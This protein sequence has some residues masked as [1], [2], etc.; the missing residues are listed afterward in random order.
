MWQ[1]PM[2]VHHADCYIA[3][4]YN[5]LGIFFFIFVNWIYVYLLFLKKEV[6]I[7]KADC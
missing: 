2:T 3:N 5:K 6:I 7:T 4:H 1:Q